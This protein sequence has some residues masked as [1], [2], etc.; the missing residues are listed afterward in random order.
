[1]KKELLARD[2]TVNW[3]RQRCLCLRKV[4]EEEVNTTTTTTTTEDE[5]EYK[6]PVMQTSGYE[7]ADRSEVGRLLPAYNY[8]DG[9]F[10]IGDSDSHTCVVH[11]DGIVYFWGGRNETNGKIHRF[12]LRTY[13][14]MKPISSNLDKKDSRY[15]HGFT[16]QENDPI[17]WMFGGLDNQ[18]SKYYNDLIRVDGRTCQWNWEQFTE[19]T[20]GNSEWPSRRRGHVFLY[21]ESNHSLLLFGGCGDESYSDVW[22]F[23][24]S[25]RKWTKLATTGDEIVPRGYS[26]GILMKKD[27]TDVLVI[28]GGDIGVDNQ[29]LTNQLCILNLSTLVWKT[30]DN[31]I[32][33]PLFGHAGTTC[34]ISNDEMFIFGGCNDDYIPYSDSYIYNLKYNTW[35]LLE[36]ENILPLNCSSIFID[37]ERGIINLYGGYDEQ[38][39]TDTHIVIQVNPLYDFKIYRTFPKLYST[40]NRQ[41]Y[42]DILIKSIE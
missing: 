40:L 37:E 39:R 14:W 7:L 13:T 20:D 25:L 33:P 28:Y 42:T 34:K 38:R 10:S 19:P 12:D 26:S 15:Y 24:I 8:F 1:M 2:G 6:E 31:S 9:R 18:E 29:T 30:Y 36:V 35:T 41:I 5:D 3:F 23:N 11:H 21:R 32:T 22:E 27:N 4:E 16:K 17:F